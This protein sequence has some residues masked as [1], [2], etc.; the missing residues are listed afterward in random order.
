MSVGRI[1]TRRVLIARPHEDAQV[2]ARRMADHELG[3]V[4]VLGGDDRPIGI[5]TDRDITVRCVALGK[6]ADTVAVAELMSSPVV[7]VGESCPIE[8]ALRRMKQTGMRRLVVTEDGD[9]TRLVGVLAIDD[10]VS[11]IAEETRMIGELL[12]RQA[13]RI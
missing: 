7:T 9:P 4:V 5:L 10:V 11:L 1:C 6:N 13:P 12:D 2:A 8:D 3:T